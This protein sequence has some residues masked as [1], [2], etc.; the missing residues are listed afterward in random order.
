MDA[1]FWRQRWV[2]Q[3]IHFHK[4]S[5]NQRL[6]RHVCRL[7]LEAGDR[8]FV[9]LCGKS[10]DVMWLSQQGHRVVG[11]ELSD[12]AVRDFFVEQALESMVVQHPQFDEHRF[13]DSVIYCGDFFD[14]NPEYLTDTVAV[15]DRAA[16]IA[17]PPPMRRR[18]VEHLRVL[19]P[20]GVRTLL[21]TLDYDQ[22]EMSGPPFS[23]P[24]SEVRELYQA[25]YA[26]E[27]LETEEVL[28]EHERF[29]QKGLTGLF[30]NVYL[31]EP[32]G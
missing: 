30:E 23:V 9:P 6:E 26:I 1:E 27:T 19:F 31:L 18:Y 13:G 17:L 15:Y 7:S 24:E 25:H 10:L 4:D 32:R 22:G 14:L 20:H 3:N 12:I 21:V 2:E 29:A 8:V 16:L 28:A 11:I 5:L